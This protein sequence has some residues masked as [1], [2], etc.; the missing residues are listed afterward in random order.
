[1]SKSGSVASPTASIVRLRR[2]PLPGAFVEV[3]AAE[4]ASDAPALRGALLVVER[5]RGGWR[6]DESLLAGARRMERWA[7]TR[8]NGAPYQFVGYAASTPNSTS[9][10]IATA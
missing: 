4:H 3:Q 2:A 10:I 9:T 6:P 7:A 8:Q 5:L 1:M